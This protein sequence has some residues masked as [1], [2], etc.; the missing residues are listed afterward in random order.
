[1]DERMPAAASCPV[2]GTPSRP[3]GRFCQSCGSALLAAITTSSP[4]VHRPRPRRRGRFALAAVA[5]LVVA[6]GIALAAARVARQPVAIAGAVGADA[7]A[8]AAQKLGAF[9]DAVTRSQDTG[10]LVPVDVSLTDAEISSYASLGWDGRRQA[11]IRDVRVHVLPGGRLEASAV[12]RG[13]PVYL[14]GLLTAPGGSLRV[15]LTDARVGVLPMPGFLLWGLRPVLDTVTGSGGRSLRGWSVRT[16][17]GVVRL[18]AVARPAS[19]TGVAAD[20][21]RLQGTWVNDDP[22]TRG[23]HAVVVDTVRDTVTVRPFGRCHP[24]DCDWGANWVVY[25]GQPVRVHFD[26]AGGAPS[27]DLSLSTNGD[28]LRVAIAGGDVETF[29]LGALPPEVQP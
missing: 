10:E 24:T 19:V 13:F 3:G 27:Q 25:E 11:D 26:F 16:D 28:S 12:Y 7:G 8:S 5:V 20:E 2:C 17:A 21:L 29:H 1:M 22:D 14:A 4:A 23:I 15:D 18:T 6:A 9:D